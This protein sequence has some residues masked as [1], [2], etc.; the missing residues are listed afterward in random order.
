MRAVFSPRSWNQPA[1]K[2]KGF[3]RSEYGGMSV[4]FAI[5]FTAIMMIITAFV[6]LSVQIATASDVQQASHDLTRQSLR[7][8][9]AGLSAEEVCGNLRQHV[10]PYIMEYSTFA[11]L[12]RVKGISCNVDEAG[13]F[14]VVT[15]T[16]DLKGTFIERSASLFGLSVDSFTRTAKLFL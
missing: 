8:V 1:L 11:D 14:S 6:A 13:E 3:I 9:D 12:D 2:I 5:L 10:L 15:V 16:Y 4:E 7:F